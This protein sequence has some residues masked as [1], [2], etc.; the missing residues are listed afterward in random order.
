[1]ISYKSQRQCVENAEKLTYSNR[2]VAAVTKIHIVRLRKNAKVEFSIDE[3]KKE[4]VLVNHELYASVDVIL[5][6]ARSESKVSKKSAKH[7]ESIRRI[8]K[9]KVEKEEKLFISKILRSRK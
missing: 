2:V 9:R 6:A 4:V 5:I 3:K 1:M 8:L 7:H